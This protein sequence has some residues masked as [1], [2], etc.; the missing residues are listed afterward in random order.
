ML[1]IPGYTLR[2]AIRSTGTNL[3][4]HAVRDADGLPLILKI[5]AASAPSPRERERYRREFS[6]LQRLRDVHG[7]T[8]VHACEQLQGRPVLLLEHIEGEPLSELTGQP[9]E[10]VRALDLAISLASTLAELH[11]RTIIHK[12]IKPSNIIITP[13][14]QTRLIDFGTAIAQLVEHVDA[15]QADLLEG[16]L[17]YMSP[18]QTGRMNRVVDYRTDFYSLGITLYELLTG[19]RPFHGR[20]ALEWC[21]AHIALAPQ[22]PSERVPELSS[23]LSAIVMK[24]LAKAAE[25]RYQSAEGLKADL[26]RC[27][28]GLSRGVREDFLPG[29]HDLPTRFQLPQRLYGRDTHSAVL[30]QG[31]LRV[32]RGGQ[33]ELI[34]VRGYSGI[35]KSAVVQELHRP[36]VRQ[37]GFFLSGKFD[38]FQQAIPYATVARALRGLTQQ[39]LGG[40][41]EELERW[42]EH[43]CEAWEGQG[44]VLVDVVPQL[45]LVVGKQP[46]VPELPPSDAQHRFN[47]VFRQLLGVFATPE[48]PLVLFLDDLQWADLASLQLLQ[49]LLTHPETTRP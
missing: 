14:G 2:G 34:L 4:F 38:Q 11:R 17:A 6:I 21:H 43:L 44:Q 9:L 32:A 25:E 46:P 35:G 7:V 36:V 18:E 5:P 31:L 33:P 10:V 3:L 26:E 24:L 27:R 42:R 16:T 39:L 8:R 23:T 12:D 41:N 48:H 13:S 28:E 45:E 1:H 15:A 22:P 19:S 49:H 37:R 20:D 47:R 29:M 40:T 30:L